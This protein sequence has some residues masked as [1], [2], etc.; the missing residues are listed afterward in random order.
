[1]IQ[2]SMLTYPK[3]VAV[4]P[5]A[6]KPPHKGHL[7]MVRKYAANAD[8]VVVIISKPTKQGRYLP[9]GREITSEDSLKI[10]QTLAVV[11]L[12][13]ELKLQKTMLPCNCSI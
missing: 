5:G 2:W 6:F 1:M 10:W 9:D 11:Y 3:T 8:E 13:F 12:M 4:V 7:D